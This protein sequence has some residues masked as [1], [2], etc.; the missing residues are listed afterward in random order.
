MGHTGLGKTTIAN[1]IANEMGVS[2]KSQSTPNI[3]KV[4]NLV[5]LLGN[6]TRK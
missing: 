3:E 4:R 1:I 5:T 2:I 6:T